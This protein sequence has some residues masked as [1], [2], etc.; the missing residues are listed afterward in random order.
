MRGERQS[1]EREER[2]REIQVSEGRETVRGE[3]R[4][5]WGDS[6]E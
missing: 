5:R 4:E 2:D 6:G 1:E 3:R